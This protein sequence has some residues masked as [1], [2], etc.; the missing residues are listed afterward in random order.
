MSTKLVMTWPQIK[1][2]LSTFSID[3]LNNFI[4]VTP[5]NCINKVFRN[6]KFLDCCKSFSFAVKKK[7]KKN[8][9]TDK[10]KFGEDSVLNQSKVFG[11]LCKTSSIILV[12]YNLNQLQ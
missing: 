12:K 9:R 11:K 4:L 6:I 3:I 2:H 1:Q 8:D 10:T 7:K 5:K